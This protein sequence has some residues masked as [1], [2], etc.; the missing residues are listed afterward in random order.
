M[1]RDGTVEVGNF[2]WPPA[3]TMVGPIRHP[4]I[5]S[6]DKDNTLLVI[7]RRRQS[8]EVYVNGTPI[9]QPIQLREPL[10]S[11]CPGLGLWERCGH[12]ELKGRAEFRR[13]TVWQLPPP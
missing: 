3:V 10:T 6:G 7:L 9:C 2:W 5:H 11:V 13:F 4:A 1:R 8:L 12:P